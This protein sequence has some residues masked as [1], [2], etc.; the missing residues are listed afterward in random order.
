MKER[1]F[2]G[3]CVMGIPGGGF[4]NLACVSRIAEKLPRTENRIIGGVRGK[5]YWFDNVP[6][7]EK[8]YR[9]KA[10]E[11]GNPPRWV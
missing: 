2:Y 4:F 8:F 5:T 3:V 7:A 6:E 1:Y 10:D 9:K 11:T